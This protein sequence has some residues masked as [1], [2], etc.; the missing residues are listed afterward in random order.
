M[1][2]SALIFPS[3]LPSAPAAVSEPLPTQQLAG[4]VAYAPSRY[5]GLPAPRYRAT[6][7]IQL[8][9]G[10][11]GQRLVGTQQ[12]L[13][14]VQ[15]VAGMQVKLL[16]ANHFALRIVEP[17]RLHRQHRGADFAAAVAGITRGRQG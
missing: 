12:P 2:D 13:R 1:S 4:F 10:P 6:A 14:I 17:V 3:R 5:V 7:V 8:T 9:V 11:H 15:P 16:L